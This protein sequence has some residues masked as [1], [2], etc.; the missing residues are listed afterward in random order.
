MALCISWVCADT[1]PEELVS[2]LTDLKTSTVSVL[3]IQHLLKV[4]YAACRLTFLD[5]MFGN[6]LCFSPYDGQLGTG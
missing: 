6:R 5:I 2:T 1:E 4:E 3:N